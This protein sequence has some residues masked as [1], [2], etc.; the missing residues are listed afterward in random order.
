MGS[1]ASDLRMVSTCLDTLCGSVLV[2]LLV[3]VPSF[4]TGWERGASRDGGGYR[5]HADQWDHRV[6]IGR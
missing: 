1:S 5:G 3:R 4:G 6:H 2:V